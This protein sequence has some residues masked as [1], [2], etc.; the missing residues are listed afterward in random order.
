MRDELRLKKEL[1]RDKLVDNEAY[2]KEKASLKARKAETRKEIQ[3]DK[4]KTGRND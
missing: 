1:L 2:D 4:A 3:A